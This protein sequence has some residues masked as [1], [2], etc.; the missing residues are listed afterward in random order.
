MGKPDLEL[1]TSSSLTLLLQNA[2]VILKFAADIQIMMS[3][4]LLLDHQRQDLLPK[5]HQKSQHH[6]LQSP[7]I[8]IT[9]LELVALTDKDV[10]DITKEESE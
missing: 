7:R 5:L 9:A 2:Q 10:E 3:T 6:H 4:T 1:T 8:Q